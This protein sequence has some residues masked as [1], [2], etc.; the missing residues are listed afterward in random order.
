MY[1][2]AGWRSVS[3]CQRPEGDSYIITEDD[4]Q[5]I[6]DIVIGNLTDEDLYTLK[7]LHETDVKLGRRISALDERINESTQVLSQEEY[8]KLVKDNAV[9]ENVTYYTYE[10]EGSDDESKGDNQIEGG[11][12]D[13]DKQA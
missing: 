2:Y 11:D 9:K 6:A 5:A 12:N 1:A 8:D 3:V 4:Y 10:D 13:T 7:S